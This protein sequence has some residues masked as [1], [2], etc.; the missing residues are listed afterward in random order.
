MSKKGLTYLLFFV[1]LVGGFYAA[2]VIFTDF[3]KVKFG[4]EADRRIGM[5][6]LN[7]PGEDG[8]GFGGHCLPK[9]LNCLSHVYDHADFWSTVIAANQSF[10]KKNNQNT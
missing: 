1:V 5:D 9:D 10:L 7:V 6:Q 2:L 3:E 4:V 8:F